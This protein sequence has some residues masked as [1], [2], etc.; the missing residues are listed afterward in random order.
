[1]VHHDK[2]INFAIENLNYYEKHLRMQTD[3]NV[4]FP[5]ALDKMLNTL[6]S[7]HRS[8]AISQLKN[9][10]NL[11]TKYEPRSRQ[12]EEDFHNWSTRKRDVKY[13]EKQQKKA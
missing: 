11:P 6:K 7:I 1:M 2:D 10:N 4:Q 3:I 12:E 9:D 5:G 8:G 13:E